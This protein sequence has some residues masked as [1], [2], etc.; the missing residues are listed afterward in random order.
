MAWLIALVLAL[1]A[2]A[3]VAAWARNDVAARVSGAV[4]GAATFACCVAAAMV[5][6]GSGPA[7]VTRWLRVDELSVI[8]LL[9]TGFL[10]MVSAMYSAGLLAHTSDDVYRRRLLSGLH[11]FALAMLAVPVVNEIALL[12]TAIEVTTVI[13]A[14][15]VMLEDTEPAL[16]AAWKYIL[17]ASAGLG[18]ALLATILMYFAGTV[19]FGAHYQPYLDLLARHAG[20]YPPVVTELV[21]V[22]AVLGFGTKVG[23]FPVHTWLP[24][25]HSE[26]AT[27][28]SALL[29]GS[30]LGVSFYAILR[31]YVIARAAIG[32]DVP[33]RTLL[34]FGIATLLLAALYL[35]RQGNIKRLLAYSSIEHMGILAIACGF[36]APLALAGMLLQVLAHAAAKSTAFFGAGALTLRFGGRDLSLMRGGLSAL[37]WSGSMFLMA[38]LALAAAPPFG[39][40][41]S[42]FQ[43]VLGGLSAGSYG[44]VTVMV[45]LV[46]VAFFGLALHATRILLSPLPPGVGRAEASPWTLAAMACGVIALLVLGIHPPT[47]LALLLERAA[48]HLGAR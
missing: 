42:E 11:L 14:L 33:R 19:A 13:S 31:Y 44:P 28:V 6:A 22:L 25:A 3:A 4:L 17:I 38:V 35:L 12:W 45:V 36:G 48:S 10:Y 40:F 9:A 23:F 39:I 20:T 32:P 5:V 18:I 8:F 2:V 26:A 43:I 30:L 1:P 34:G 16:E 41:R 15:L 21:L 7:E 46:T 37:P 27:P 47:D 29:S 24:D